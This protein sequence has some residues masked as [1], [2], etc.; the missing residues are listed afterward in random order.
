MNWRKVDHYALRSVEPDGKDGPYTITRWTDKAGDSFCLWRLRLHVSTHPTPD[1][2]K[3][4]AD[5]H[6]AR[7]AAGEP[8]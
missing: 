5:A 3:A 1:E 7:W 4:A 2:A 8:A 6:A